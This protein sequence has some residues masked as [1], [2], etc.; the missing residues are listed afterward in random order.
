MK[1][2]KYIYLQMRMSLN[3]FF[4][5]INSLLETKITIEVR[6]SKRY[7]KSFEQ[8]NLN[9]NGLY[10]VFFVLPAN[11]T[12]SSEEFCP[13]QRGPQIFCDGRCFL[14]ADAVCNGRANCLHKKDEKNC[15]TLASWNQHGSRLCFLNQCFITFVE[16]E[17]HRLTNTCFMAYTRPIILF[18]RLSDR[19]NKILNILFYILLILPPPY[20]IIITV[21]KFYNLHRSECTPVGITY[22]QC[23]KNFR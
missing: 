2:V 18:S 14:R 15:G 20:S 7:N 3:L 21:H 22:L 13:A 19:I 1:S 9:K 17:Y 11:N 4:S 8:K 10:I 12:I 6:K 23:I 5:L 16:A